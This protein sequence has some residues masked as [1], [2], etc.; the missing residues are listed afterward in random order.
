V[1]RRIEHAIEDLDNV[2]RVLRDAVFGLE[3]QLKDRGL[4]ARILYLCERLSP[5]PDVSFRGPVDGALHPNTGNQLL[6]VLREALGAIAQHWTPVRVDVTA[7]DGGALAVVIHAAAPPAPPGR[8]AHGDELARL[9]AS[10]AQAGKRVELESGREAIRFA[11]H[12][13]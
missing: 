3:H 7:D 1:R 6:E 5:A 8:S 2:I 13:P 4:R 11:W 9:R 12:V 10:A